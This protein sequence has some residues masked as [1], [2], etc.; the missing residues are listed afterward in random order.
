MTTPERS[1]VEIIVVLGGKLTFIR[2]TI[3]SLTR[4]ELSEGCRI[5]LL[6]NNC[7]GATTEYLLSVVQDHPGIRFIAIEDSLVVSVNDIIRE[8]A[9]E[10]ICFVL[11]NVIVPTNWL[12]EMLS[13]MS[14]NDNAG[15]VMT[16]SN[17]GVGVGVPMPAGCT[18]NTMDWFFKARRTT[19]VSAVYL[20]MSA[21]VLVESNSFREKG[22]LDEAYKTMAWA[23]LDR[24]VDNVG[25]GPQARLAETVY[26]YRY[27]DDAVSETEQDSAYLLSKPGSGNNLKRLATHN[28]Q[29]LSPLLGELALD[30]R[31]SPLTTAREAYRILRSHFR[32][33]E[34]LGLVKAA[35]LGLARLPTGSTSIASENF[36]SRMVCPKKL[37]VTYVLHN[38]TVAGG[39]ISVVQLANELVLL[40][41]EVRV[42]ALY[43]YPETEG[44]KWY[45]QP[46]IYKDANDLISNFPESDVVIA[47]HWT[48]ADWVAAVVQ[49]GR[50]KTSAYFLQD[51]ESWFFPESDS[52]SRAVVL[53]TYSKI[54]NKIVKSSWLQNLIQNDGFPSKKIWLGLDLATYYPRNVP[55]NSATTIV[56]MARP[57]TPRRGFHNL[58]EALKL[59]K[60]EY[61][62][63]EIILFGEDLSDH[64]IPFDYEGVGVISSPDSMAKLYSRSSVFIDASDFQGF[65]RTALEAMACNV[66]CILTDQGGVS[67]Y[68]EN[69]EN[70]ILV[71][72][73]QPQSIFEAFGNIV[74]DKSLCE[75][76]MVNG[77][78]TAK[79][80]CHKREATETATFFKSLT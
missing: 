12:D 30:E 71:S 38:I 53:E 29:Q 27:S 17:T 1:K 2:E 77:L 10:Y 69:Y 78:E 49:N 7:D 14:G 57:G 62:A 22:L 79:K 41:I 3:A 80:F 64:V 46:I 16:L 36:T 68:A 39:V 21:C 43:Q 44:W 26:V 37:R 23:L 63:T 72:P 33:R 54:D 75:K 28:A 48:T 56:A 66:A 47:T 52:K 34:Y 11:G 70:C 67:E 73:G 40:G 4:D 59:I 65:G 58:V 45:T 15:E 55:R 20:D 13:A 42:V 18:L 25:E 60:S 51:Y 5:S 76:I 31:W 24:S 74:S 6:G 19:R 9:S 35:L 50:A 32:G 8:T 61:P